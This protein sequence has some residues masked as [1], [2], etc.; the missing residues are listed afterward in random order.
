MRGVDSK[1]STGRAAW[2]REG[3]RDVC[4]LQQKP[5]DQTGHLLC[6]VSQILPR[7]KSALNPSA[8]I[9]ALTLPLPGE[10]Q[11][12]KQPLKHLETGQ[13]DV[14]SISEDPPPKKQNI[15]RAGVT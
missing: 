10:P 13:P 4:V 11:P 9:D 14:S 1:L 6:L 3:G 2:E 7:K 12:Q 15:P 8:V 5:E